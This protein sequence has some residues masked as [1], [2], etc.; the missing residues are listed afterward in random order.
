MSTLILKSLNHL[1]KILK[2]YF[3]LAVVGALVVIVYG[4]CFSR[5]GVVII[6]II[7][8]SLGFIAIMLSAQARKASLKNVTDEHEH[9]EPP[10]L[11][12][13]LM[14]FLL[15]TRLAEQIIGDLRSDF[16]RLLM[17]YGRMSAAAWYAVESMRIVVHTIASQLMSVLFRGKSSS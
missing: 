11:P 9:N 2:V 17:K 14:S 3:T 16:D 1:Y 10:K 4:L 8:L 13:S 7:D 15:P 6:L 5:P 12:E